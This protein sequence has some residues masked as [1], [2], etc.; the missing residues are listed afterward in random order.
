MKIVPYPLPPAS[1]DVLHSH[2]D[3]LSPMHASTLKFLDES[4]EEAYKKYVREKSLTENAHNPSVRTRYL[5]F[6]SLY[7]SALIFILVVHV[8]DSLVHS[9][10][11]KILVA[12]QIVVT[13]VLMA[14]GLMTVTLTYFYSD[15]RKS[16]SMAFI[17]LYIFTATGLSLTDK[18]VISFYIHGTCD[19]QHLSA[20][21]PILLITFALENII[22]YDFI[23]YCL[24]GVAISLIY[25]AVVLTGAQDSHITVFQS[26]FLLLFIA[27]NTKRLYQLERISRKLFY[28]EMAER[29][30]KLIPSF[31]SKSRDANTPEEGY[32]TELENIM[33]LINSSISIVGEASEVV[34]YDDLRGKL[35]QALQNLT[36]A[37]TK[38]KA[39]PHI[40]EAKLETMNPNI[41]EE[42][43]IFVEENFL[44]KPMFSQEFQAQRLVERR[45]VDLKLTCDFEEVVTV[46]NQMGRNWNFDTFFLQECTSGKALSISA[47]YFLESFNLIDKFSLSDPIISSYFE[48]MEQSYK[49]NPYHNSC[50]AA[51]VLSSCLYISKA[52]VLF[53]YMTDIEIL[54]LVIATL[55]HDVGHQALTNRFLVSNRDQLAITYNDLSVLENMH[56]S[57]T[58]TL[59][60]GEGRNILHPLDSD[61][62][63]IARKVILKMILA[64][65]MSRH[66]ELL[67]QFKAG[68]CT[69]LSTA[70]NKMEER[71]QVL[72]I[73]IKCGDIGHAAKCLD[74]HE[75]WTLLVCEEF[76]NQGDMEKALGQQVS[77]YCDRDTTDIAKS[78]SGFIANI[79]MPLFLSLN[80]YLDSVGIETYCL[81]Q[82]REN[83]EHWDAKTVIKRRYTIKAR[84]TGQ[85]VT[86][87][88]QVLKEKLR[89]WK[90]G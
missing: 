26:F 63:S 33:R 80:G 64:T 32:N 6:S 61:S 31:T 13:V 47:R 85:E 25:L 5:S 68:H 67:G 11:G 43:R 56:A 57:F 44:Q 39:G 30:L 20:L 38:L 52:S 22:Y 24:S 21:F 10:G 77:M 7:F 69:P 66:F 55:G 4:L 2:M 87:E 58:F 17:F 83:K 27:G 18:S 79:V 8:I 84:V 76:F 1:Q 75:K 73:I 53:S 49:P 51:D 28:M 42:D 23:V 90:R 36:Q 72:E 82:L 88:F 71:L 65:D 9:E 54:A 40:F 46:L 86:N 16:A 81:S 59:M 35:K 19:T 3:N 45:P 14:V 34:I 74:L 78:Q 70:L 41:D 48:A 50:H 29:D 12:V 15:R 37:T 89:S 62:W 60:Q